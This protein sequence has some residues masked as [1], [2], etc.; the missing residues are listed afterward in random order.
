MWLI[1]AQQFLRAA[2]QVFFGTWFATLLTRAPDIPSDQVARLSSLPPVLLIIG[3][4]VGGI[5]SDW[6]LWRTGSRRISR[7]WLTV[8]SLT[9]CAAMFLLA[10]LVDSGYTRVTLIAIGCFFMTTGG[11]SSYAIT[12][13]LGGRHVGAVFSIMNMFGSFGAACFPKYAGWLVTRTGDW[14]DV[15][16]SIAVIY[17]GAAVCWALLN[18]TGTLL[19]D[20]SKSELATT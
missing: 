9:V 5:V 11:V 1:C 4:F 12:L 19:S 6:L 10:A 14:N 2:A 20:S 8:V 16:I 13:D 7:Q 17:V 15:L 3:S 18:P